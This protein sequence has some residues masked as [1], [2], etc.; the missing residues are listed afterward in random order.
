M[1]ITG[2]ALASGSYDLSWWAT[3]GGGGSST[4]SSPGYSLSGAI[5]QPAT[6]AMTGT[7][8]QLSG[9]FWAGGVSSPGPGHLLYLPLV[10]K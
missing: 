3:P 10:K 8:Y 1:M 4:S 7:G 5:G 2:T 9:G 6:N